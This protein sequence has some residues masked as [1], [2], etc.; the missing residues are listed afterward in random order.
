MEG[1][2]G[3]RRRTLPGKRCARVGHKFVLSAAT[4]SLIGLPKS[5]HDNRKI[6]RCYET[7]RLTGQQRRKGRNS[8]YLANVTYVLGSR[9]LCEAVFALTDAAVLKEKISDIAS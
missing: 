4:E 6:F 2:N 8:A 5:H 9:T 1:G 7:D 3:G